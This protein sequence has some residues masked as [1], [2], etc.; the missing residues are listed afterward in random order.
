LVGMYESSGLGPHYNL[1]YPDYLDWKRMSRSFAGI[2]AYDS[3]SRAMKTA[4]GLEL[5]G[6]SRV[7]AGFLRMLGVAPVLGRDFREGEDGKDASPVALLSYAAWQRRYGG[8]SMALGQTV[9]LEGQAY[10]IVGVLPQ[11]FSFAGAGEAEFWVPLKGS[12]GD[13]RGE[14]W[15]SALGRLRDGVDLRS[16]Q[17]EMSGIM[18]NLARQY[19]DSDG[20]R[21]ATVESWT[22]LVVGEVRPVLLLMMVGS[23]LLLSMA[24]VNV[25]SLLLVRAEK[26]RREVAVRGALGASRMR[27]MRQFV[28]E[29]LLLSL[30]GCGLGVSVA[31]VVIRMLRVSIPA[32]LLDSM[33]YLRD[34][35]LNWH[36]AAFAALTALGTGLLFALMPLLRLAGTVL[37]MRGGLSG[38]GR[39]D[40]RTSTGG[41]WRRMGANLVVVQMML[42]VVLLTGAG[43]L[44]RSLYEL[45][46]VDLG[47]EA[48]NL[49]LVHL[50]MPPGTAEL[51]RGPEVLALARRAVEA[52][53]Q[54]PGAESV[55]I[56]R[57]LPVNNGIGA[58]T[59]F[60][61]VGRPT[62]RNG[63]A[64]LATQRM[65]SPNLFATL[66]TRLLRG[67]GFTD[68]DDA[69]HPLAVI[70]NAQFAR[71][72]FPGEDAI[73]RQLQIDSTMPRMTIV[74]VIEDMREGALDGEIA[75]AIYQPFAQAP[76]GDFFVVAR[77]SGDPE[78]FA[79]VLEAKLRGLRS[80]L[81]VYSAET[82]EDRIRNTQAAG[83]H[84][85]SAALVGG[86]AVLALV[87]SAVGLYG[88]I[89]YSVSQR[90]REI[91]VRMALGASRGDVSGMV[92][93]E[94]SLLLG[95]G[96]GL[97]LVCAVGAAALMRSLLYGT[98]PWDMPTLLSVAVLLGVCALLA[99]YLPARRAASVNP[100]DALRAE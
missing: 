85:A 56:S 26:R 41:L 66:K 58:N 33:P 25:A 21:G 51:Q 61:I 27:L 92:L 89:A 1:S 18:A 36:M 68:A 83:M 37:E 100:M 93:R 40:S 9:V 48:G 59:G 30:L 53:R 7:S 70:V 71:R 63:T 42:A 81:L 44:T 16:A 31:C 4:S 50:R 5:V 95:M 13:D 87:L 35:G 60:L 98:A 94:A 47:M 19:P 78:V 38:E 75:P 20:E 77:V 84:R 90:T 12:A 57:H 23:M 80:D 34:V 32:G 65:V 49:A 28:V 39:T 6:T 54:I 76:E 86:F 11:D 52:A 10:Q 79:Q 22:E 97:G 72:Y 73:G 17:A 99:S 91:G 24:G 14:H 8:S 46:H 96:L 3:G 15:F 55:A 43:L 45:V 74:G 82:M 69:T 64:N 88:V 62:P 2:E 67:R 29:G